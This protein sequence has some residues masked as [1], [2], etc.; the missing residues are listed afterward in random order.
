MEEVCKINGVRFIN[1][2]KA[3]TADSAIWATNDINTPIILIA[4]GKHKGIDYRVIIEP[5]R[6][7]VKQLIL[8]GEAKE[9]IA[10]ALGD[11]FPI[12]NAS[13]LKEAVEKASALAKPGYTV[14]FSPM[15]AS[16]DMFKDYEERG[17]TFKKIVLNLAG[18]KV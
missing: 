9:N 1:D 14:L 2:S 6:N 18:D 4:G 11:E 8:I 17:R 12:E 3:T 13:S 5:A 10:A 7:K 16:Y 15:C